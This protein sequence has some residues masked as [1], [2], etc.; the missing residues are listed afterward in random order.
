MI[1][2]RNIPWNFFRCFFR[3]YSIF[4]ISLELFSTH[5]FPPHLY[6]ASV[7]VGMP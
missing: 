2:S 1:D 4:V 3:V 6:A 5:L 7:V